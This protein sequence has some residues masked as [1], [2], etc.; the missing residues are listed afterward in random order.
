MHMGYQIAYGFTGDAKRVDLWKIRLKYLGIAAVGVLFIISV[1]WIS[2]VNWPVTV[3]AM[4]EMAETLS[5]GE[6]FVD[7]FSAFCIHVLQGAE[8]G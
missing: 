7:A 2:D 5:Q 1:L 6:N 3:S 4:E 8:C